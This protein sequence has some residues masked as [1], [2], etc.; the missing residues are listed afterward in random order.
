MPENACDRCFLVHSGFGNCVV[1]GE[2]ADHHWV[3]GPLPYSRADL[4]ES[5]LP[6]LPLP[7]A[8]ERL[9]S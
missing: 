3:P 9:G 2:N 8:S 7:C 6:S 4:N 5:S 1:L